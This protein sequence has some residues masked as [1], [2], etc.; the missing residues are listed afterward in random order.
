VRLTRVAVVVAAMA[1]AAP[2]LAQAVAP[3]GVT[4]ISL[5]ARVELAWQPVLGASAYQVYRGTS[6]GAIT[7]RVTP[8]VGTTSTTFSDATA[9]NGTTYYY[10]VRAIEGGT[11][12]ADS[13]VVQAT[14]RLPSC[15]TGNPIVRE[16]CFPGDAGWRVQSTASVSSGGIEGYATATSVDKGGSVGLK[17]NSAAGS[18]FRIEIYRSGFYGATG[19]RLISTIRRVPGAAQPTCATDGPTG[20]I[21]C[22]TSTRAGRRRCRSAPGCTSRRPGTGATIRLYVSG[23]QVATR[24]AGGSMA[25]SSGPLRLGGNAVWGE[26]LR[27]RLDEVRVYNRA[28]STAEILAEMNRAV[29]Q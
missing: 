17:V 19:G 2:A 26:W 9:A 12:S 10:A 4:G 23:T 1:L 6:M 24:A 13:L 3:A 22:S 27:G 20:L 5:D 29:R 11:E 8:S 14:P 28:L 16:N 15:T 25:N 7:T 21:D 18:T